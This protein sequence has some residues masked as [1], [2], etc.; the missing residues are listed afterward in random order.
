VTINPDDRPAGPAAL[1]GSADQS[2]GEPLSGYAGNVVIILGSITF[3]V[4]GATAAA[5]FQ[6]LLRKRG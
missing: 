1:R 2:G 4:H 5:H 3:S 6:L